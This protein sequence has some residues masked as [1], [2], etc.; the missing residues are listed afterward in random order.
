MITI[1]HLLLGCCLLAAGAV[2]PTPGT[3]A[4]QIPT[5]SS[6][7]VRYGY[8]MAD[9]WLTVDL[10]QQIER[11]LS[12]SQEKQSHQ[13]SEFEQLQQSV[14]H[15]ES[16]LLDARNLYKRA[17]ATNSAERIAR[18]SALLDQTAMIEAENE[19]A[20]MA[21]L[22]NLGEQASGGQFQAVPVSKQM[23]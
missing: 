17:F 11:G 5:L 3:A 8:L 7:A 2:V 20:T 14:A 22:Q 4:E 18:L 15:T 16:S 23:L 6:C 9:H 12:Y 1:N 19:K 21:L 10:A 13:R